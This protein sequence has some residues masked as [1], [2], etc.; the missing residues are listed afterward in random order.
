MLQARL[1]DSIP[2]D[3]RHRVMFRLHQ[4]LAPALLRDEA[5]LVPLL[6]QERPEVAAKR[7]LAQK[8]LA[9]LQAAIAKLE[10]I[11]CDGHQNR[12]PMH[13]PQAR[14]KAGGTPNEP[15]ADLADFE[16]VMYESALS[17]APS[18]RQ[19]PPLSV[20]S[21]KLA[22]ADPLAGADALLQHSAPSSPRGQS[23]TAISSPLLDRGAGVVGPSPGEGR[24]SFSSAII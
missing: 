15:A 18:R 5:M 17:A 20:L 9:S 10:L 24:L 3:I 23:P 19:T 11:A 22:G 2:I 14:V 21:S 13:T 7:A 1:F 12:G 8:Q 6:T 16:Y 4:R